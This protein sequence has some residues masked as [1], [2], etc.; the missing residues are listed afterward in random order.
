[1]NLH[2]LI[3]LLMASVGVFLALLGFAVAQTQPRYIADLG[4]FTK[5]RCALGLLG[6]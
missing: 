1:L 5:S 3:G 4:E 2:V 6:H